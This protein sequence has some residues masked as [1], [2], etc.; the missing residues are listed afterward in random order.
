MLI[1]KLVSSTAFESVKYFVIVKK[2]I[3]YSSKY[4]TI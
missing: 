1:F 2:T 3:N 4:D